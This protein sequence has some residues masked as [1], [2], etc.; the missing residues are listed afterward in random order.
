MPKESCMS[1]VWRDAW[2]ISRAQSFDRAL[3]SRR[4]PV[5]RWLV[6][7]AAASFALSFVTTLS[8]GKLWLGP[9]T[10]VLG[11]VGGAFAVAVA[12]LARMWAES[13]AAASLD[14]PTLNTKRLLWI[15]AAC[16]VASSAILLIAF[17]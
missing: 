8:R 7:L 10:L 9:Q 2:L 17:Q 12:L 14:R 6:V 4:F 13:A 16:F 11:L 1:L 3:H 5:F 15:I